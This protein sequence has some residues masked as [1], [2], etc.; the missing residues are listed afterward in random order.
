MMWLC[1]NCIWRRKSQLLSKSDVT[2]WNPCMIDYRMLAGNHISNLGSVCYVGSTWSSLRK[3]C[4]LFIDS[5]VHTQC[6]G[7]H[8]ME[9]KFSSV[10]HYEETRCKLTF[11]INGVHNQRAKMFSEPS[12][13]DGGLSH[14][15]HGIVND[16]IRQHELKILKYQIPHQKLRKVFVEE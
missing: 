15:G 9:T 4:I 3:H 12:H 6:C 10:Q 16:C 14:M 5:Y 13:N 2:P 1:K 7:A 11:E 8:P